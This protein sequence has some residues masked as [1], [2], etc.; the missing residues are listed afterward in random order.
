[1][2]KEKE[3]NIWRGKMSP[4]RDKQRTW[5]DLDFF[6]RKNCLCENFFGVKVFL[7]EN[8]FWVKNLCWVKLLG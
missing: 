4:W 3:K 2:E 7:G 5:K 1:M 6:G 8:L